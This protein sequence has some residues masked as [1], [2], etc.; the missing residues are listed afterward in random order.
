MKGLVLAAGYATRLYPLTKNKAKALL[1]IKGQPILDYIVDEMWTMPDLEQIIIVSN[2]RFAKDFEAWRQTRPGEDIVV[3][4]DG[5]TSDDDKLGAIGDMQYVIDK[6]KIDDDFFVIAGDTLFTYKLKD[7]WE[8]F[9]ETNDDMILACEMPEGEDLTRFAIATVND[10]GVITSLEEKPAEPKS[11]LAVFATYFYRRDTLPLIKTYLDEGN[12]PDAPGNFPAWL[13]TRKTVKLYQFT[14]NCVDI[15]TPE[16]YA[17]VNETWP[18][19][20]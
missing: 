20:K 11:N 7:A 6:L 14:G 1:P 16:A 13:Y 19:V 8:A 15:G 18:D 2:H 17:A 3:I 10:Q 5:T 12:S 4:D 9:R